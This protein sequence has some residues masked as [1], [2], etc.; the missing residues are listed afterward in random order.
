MSLT[1]HFVLPGDIDDPLSP[2]GGNTYDRRVA[3]GLPGLGWQV[4][5]HPVPGAW[6]LPS[7]ADRAALRT[8]LSGITDGG[9]VLVDGLVATTV[10]EILAAEASRLR[11]VVLMHMP[12]A[13]AREERAL[14]CAAAVVAT[15]E[16]TRHELIRLYALPPA[17]IHVARP[18]T[19]PAAEAVPR[20]AGSRLL[21]VAAVTPNKGHDILVSALAALAGEDWTCVCAGSLTKDAAYADALRDRV[22][23]LG[24]AERILFTGARVG[25][26]LETAYLEADLLVLPSRGE[27]YG[28]VVAEALAHGVPVVATDVGGV[29]EALGGTPARRPGLLVPPDDPGRLAGALRDWLADPG[30]R[31][32]LRRAALDRRPDLPG[33]PETTRRIAEALIGVR[34]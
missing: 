12:F 31:A 3:D 6:P 30:L 8:V 34:G 10:P 11:L 18:G 14:G 26:D 21:C 1:V 20:E 4:R 24:L 23:A 19:D 33:W 28:M 22:A 29:P 7:A 5:E 9:T 15:S 25:A 13:N 27:T 2:S 16:W 32:A 17:L